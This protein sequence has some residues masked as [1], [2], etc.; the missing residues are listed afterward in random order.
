MEE[1]IFFGFS[2]SLFDFER[3]VFQLSLNIHSH[4]ISASVSVLA[5]MDFSWESPKSSSRKF[6]YFSKSHIGPIDLIFG[7]KSLEAA[8]EKRYRWHFWFEIFFLSKISFLFFDFFCPNSIEILKE[9]YLRVWKFHFLLN[10]FFQKSRI[11][12][13]SSELISTSF[14]PILLRFFLNYIY[15]VWTLSEKYTERVVFILKKVIRFSK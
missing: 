13:T 2:P 10:L 15:F 3:I 7:H 1:K 8:F 6:D 12:P 4:F 11:T 14:C 9:I 5:G